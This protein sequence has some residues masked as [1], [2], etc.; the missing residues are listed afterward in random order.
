MS[1]ENFRGDKCENILLELVCENKFVKIIYNT[2]K[3]IKCSKFCYDLC[4]HYNL[5]ALTCSLSLLFASEM[6]LE[7]RIFTDF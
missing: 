4:C 7:L 6:A 1:L 3:Y 5:I 2:E